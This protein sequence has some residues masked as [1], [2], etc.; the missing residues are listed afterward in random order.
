MSLNAADAP[1]LL[2][3]APRFI[4]RDLEQALAF[5]GKLG[6][7][8]TYHDDAFAIVSRDCVDLHLNIMQAILKDSMLSVGLASLTVMRYTSSIRRP[9]LCVLR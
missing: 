8:T 9:M 2:A 3:I 7:E 6:F 5:Y 1:T 4:V